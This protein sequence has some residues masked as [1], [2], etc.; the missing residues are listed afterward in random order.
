MCWLVVHSDE[1]TRWRALK[2]DA[3]NRD[4]WSIELITL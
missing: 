4:V 2:F 1:D 3:V